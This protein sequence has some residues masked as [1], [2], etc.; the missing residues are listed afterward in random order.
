MPWRG[1]I[2]ALTATIGVLGTPG[3]PAAADPLPAGVQEYGWYQGDSPVRIMAVG[4]GICGLTAVGGAFRGTGEYVHLDVV[5][6]YWQLSGA[7][8]QQGVAARARCVLFS[9]FQRGGVINYTV[10]SYGFTMRGGALVRQVAMWGDDAH[11]WLTG[12]GGDFGHVLPTYDYAEFVRVIGSD[13][14]GFEGKMLEGHAISRDQYIEGR[15]AC[16]AFQ[17]VATP[18]LDGYAV[19]DPYDSQL[20][21]QKRTNANI[22]RAICFFAKVGGDFAS[23][24][25]GATIGIGRFGQQYLYVNAHQIGSGFPAEDETPIAQV[26]CLQYDQR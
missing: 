8:Q 3:S 23:Q 26:Q 11:C 9:K 25:D 4:D 17:D 1:V 20:A 22:D 5:D 2:L 15:A 6:G 12:F 16:A 19:W 24:A 21:V 7:S 18:R 10:G 14:P 13:S